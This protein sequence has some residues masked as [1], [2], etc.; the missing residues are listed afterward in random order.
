MFA[1]IGRFSYRFRWVVLALWLVAFAL[2]LWAAT[3]LPGE[4]KGGGFTDPKAPAQ[5]ALDTLQR[6]LKTGLSTLEIVFASDTL[7]ATS[8]RFQADMAE[9][10]SRLTAGTVP[11]LKTIQTY[12]TTGDKELLSRDGKAALAVLV[13]DVQSEQVQTELGTIRGN[14]RAHVPTYLR[15]RRAR[16]V[17][18]D[19]RPLGQ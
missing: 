1:A 8:P 7:P 9:A 16:G 3:R 15:D 17:R 14:L 19:Q 6:R 12:A 10:L 4:L 2:G 11:G 5:Q 18:G 13:F